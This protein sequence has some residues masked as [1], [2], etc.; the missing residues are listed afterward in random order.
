MSVVND[1]QLDRIFE[2]MENCKFPWY[3]AGGWSIDLAIGRKTREHKDMDIVVFREYIQDVLDYFKDWEIGVAI[4]G[5]NRLESVE[6]KK[7]VMQPRYCLHISN[8]TDFVEV[9]LTDR[10]NTHAI[11]RRNPS[12]TI[13]LKDFIKTDSMNRSYITPEWQLL[14]KSKSP[15]DY[16]EQDYIN[17]ISYLSNRQK[18]WLKQSLVETDASY[19]WIEFL[20]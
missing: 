5:E 16:D 4:P 18:E 19:E 8:E 15:R 9:L 11:F 3:I 14:F 12:I 20:N 17:S 2:I 7:Q 1:P 6:N 10:M 13:P